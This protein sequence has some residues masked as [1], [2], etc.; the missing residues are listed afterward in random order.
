M[1]TILLLSEEFIKENSVIYNDVSPKIFT[2]AIFE[3]QNI[4]YK[5][6]LPNDLYKDIFTQFND[7]KTY[8]DEGGT[9][10]IEDQI[11]AR[12]LDLVNESKY[13][14]LYATLYNASYSLYTRITNKGIVSENSNY[15]EDIDI[16]IIEDMRKNWKQKYQSYSDLLNEYLSEN[17]S[18]YPEYSSLDSCES[19][20]KIFSNPLYLGD[21]I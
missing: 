20:S 18:A 16:N 11:D 10:P 17:N 7:Y 19:V 15:S 4:Q 2:S 14:L 5:Y 9:D 12:I 6:L 21:E 8:V 3:S 13:M 1:N